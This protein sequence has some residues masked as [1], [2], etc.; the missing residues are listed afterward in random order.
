VKFHK[1]VLTVIAVGA[2]SLSLIPSTSISAAAATGDNQC[3]RF[4]RAERSFQ[5]K[6]NFARQVA[7]K[8]ALKLDPELGKVARVH[9][10]AMARRRQIFHQSSSQLGTRVTRWSSLGENVGVGSTVTSLHTAFMN[11]PGHRA[12]ILYSSFRNVGVGTVR[13]GGRMWVVVVFES[14][15]NPGTR[16]SMPTC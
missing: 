1:K 3:Y 6:I 7:G 9:A 11:S 8:A 15:L 13:K 14:Q 10:R 4:R 5:R 16:L 12:N 2:V